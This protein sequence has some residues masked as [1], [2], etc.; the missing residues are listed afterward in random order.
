MT[1][2]RTTKYA[3]LRSFRPRFAKRIRRKELPTQKQEF[4][5]FRSG[6]KYKRR[7]EKRT[8]LYQQ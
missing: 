8:P 5:I 3:G 4:W 1:K 7:T 6:L 2:I